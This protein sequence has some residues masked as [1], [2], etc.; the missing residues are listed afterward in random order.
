MGDLGPETSPPS[1]RTWESWDHF[2]VLDKDAA[3]LHNGAPYYT[4]FSADGS[5]VVVLQQSKSA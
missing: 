1:P 3:L 2:T 5:S 4:G